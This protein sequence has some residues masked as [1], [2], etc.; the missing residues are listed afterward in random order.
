M[1]RVQVIPL[2][3]SIASGQCHPGSFAVSSQ[4]P[5]QTKLAIIS[6]FQHAIGIME[7]PSQPF[8]KLPVEIIRRIAS[9]C[10]CSTIIAL[11]KTNHFLHRTCYD[12]V[13]FHSAI[14]NRES[15]DSGVAVWRG[16]NDLE[17][18]HPDIATQD[19]PRFTTSWARY[20]LADEKSTSLGSQRAWSHYHRG[21]G[22]TW[23]PQ[24]IALKRK[25]RL[26]LHLSL[27]SC[28]IL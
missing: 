7:R 21:S 16:C 26:L 6:D 14:L 3:V 13:V 8:D 11:S 24:L 28:Q 4:C 2:R 23:V 19:S 27:A 20:A 12:P 10:P 25:S 1:P 15:S 22:S 17:K 5:A 9:F 18:W